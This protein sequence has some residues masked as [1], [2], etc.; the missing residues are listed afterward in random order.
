MKKKPTIGITIGDFNGIGPE[1]V[2]KSLQKKRILDLCH[3]IVIADSKV[4]EALQ[5]KFNKKI[6]IYE[7]S[8]RV[9]IN[10]GKPTLLSGRA[11]LNYIYEGINLIKSKSIDCLVTAPISKHAISMA[12]S[13]FKG[14]TD[15]LQES[16]KIRNVVMSFFSKDIN[17]SLSTIHIP[18]KDVITQIN[19]LIILEQIVII[20]E[21]LKQYFGLKNPKIAICAIN[22]HA[23]EDGQIGND[24][25]RITFPAVE[26]ARKKKILAYGPFPADTLFIKQHRKNYDIIHS[27]YHDQG[28]IPFKMLAFERGVNATLN[29]PFVRT[30]PDH[31]T[32]YDIAW[33]NK[34]NS[35]SMEE[36]ILLAIRMHQKS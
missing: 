22:P 24:D 6:K 35:K 33:K 2:A 10:P 9:Q 16:F 23:S 27:I 36:A 1:V 29:L 30:S 14:H 4:L 12:G 28:L 26:L 17:I 25:L 11:S 34:A 15:L 21:S 18:I 32:A 19:K 8:N 20:N 5:C 7:T 13:N 31:G 3:P